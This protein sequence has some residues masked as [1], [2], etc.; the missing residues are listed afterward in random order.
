M[1]DSHPVTLEI[2]R[3]FEVAENMASLLYHNGTVGCNPE[4]LN[5]ELYSISLIQSYLGTCKS[6]WLMLSPSYASYALPT[7]VAQGNGGE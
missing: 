5:G 7:Q 2:R 1:N 3:T 6:G 4:N